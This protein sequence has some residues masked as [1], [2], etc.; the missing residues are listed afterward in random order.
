[1]ETS[2]L[3]NP[4]ESAN[5]LQTYPVFDD[6]YA[7]ITGIDPNTNNQFYYI[8]S[9][10]ERKWLTER[11][12]TIVKTMFVH[13]CMTFSQIHS[14]FF[15]DCSRLDTVR[16]R[17]GK[18]VK[19]G[20]LRRV[21]WGSYSKVKSECPILYELGTVG[22]E[23]L[24]IKYGVQ[25]GSRDPRSNKP[26]TLTFKFKYIVTNQLYL[27][28]SK[29]DLKHFEFNPVLKLNDEVQVPMAYYI[30]RNPKGMDIQFHL[31]CYR[32]DD[33]WMKTLTYQ[34]DFFKRYY[35][36]AEN[37]RNILVVLVSD[38]AK[39]ETAMKTVQVAGLPFT[40]WFITDADLFNQ[41]IPVTSKFF[42][43]EDDGSR[44][45]YDLS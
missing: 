16:T 37:K 36:T 26:S 41:D 4:L 14:I 30:L 28:L 9:L 45:Y 22:A 40:P 24:R 13:R 32:D 39:A 2:P 1:M 21:S 20:L 5:V 42:M 7:H 10:I 17:L 8:E 19:Y 31:L 6:P 11:D 25:L 29:L 12:I 18:L 43:F 34:L 3:I 44:Y 27:E 38:D 33:K 23:F 15:P 35:Q